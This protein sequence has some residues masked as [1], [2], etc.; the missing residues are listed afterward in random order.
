MSLPSTQ[1]LRYLVAVADNLH[2][3]LAADQ[4]GIS[5]P[6]L[7][8]QLAR[9]ERLLGAQLIER[10]TRR[11]ILTPLGE[12]VVGRARHVLV[13]LEELSS[14]AKRGH[15]PLAGSFYLG[16][17]PTIA[18]YVLPTLLPGV[19]NEFP[20]LRLFLREEQTSRLLESLMRGKLD[21]AL[22][23]LPVETAG[24]E[25][26]VVGQEYFQLVVPAGHRLE[27]KARI[28]HADLA[29]E[30][31]LLLEDGHCLR[32]QALAVCELAGARETNSI[33][34]NSI[35]TL[36]QMV[37]NGLGVTLLPASAV[38]T[39]IRGM[40]EVSVVSFADPQPS[41]TLGLV[42]RSSSGRHVDFQMFGRLLKDLSK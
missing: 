13:G 17:I 41:R 26:L 12:E 36:I 38:P 27:G 39:E 40:S 3:G 24:L 30:E 7:S 31:V 22:L 33:R 8:A 32:D 5:Q 18:P 6:A 28:S 35:S 1:Q 2:F 37:A 11:V 10:T 4:C 23:A 20:D 34:A 42:W 29:D 19:R 14:M 25:S 9:L 21:A 16:V 15:A